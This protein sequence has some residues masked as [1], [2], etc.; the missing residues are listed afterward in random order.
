MNDY[1]VLIAGGG[2]GGGALALALRGSGLRIAVLETRPRETA[3]EDPRP[4][5]L[6]HGSRLILER[7]EL[8]RALDPV[9]PI[10]RI[11]VSQRGGFGRVLLDAAAVGLPALGY[12]VDYAQ[13]AARVTESLQGGW[14]DYLPGTA[15]NRVS[16]DG[17]AAVVELEPARG[18]VITGLLVVADGGMHADGNEAHAVRT[19]DYRQT[20]VTARVTSTVAHA[21]VAYERFTPEGPLALLPAGGDLAL[22][23]STTPERAQRLCAAPDAEFLGELQQAFGN[24]LGRFT[25]VTRRGMFPLALRVA[26][27]TGEPRTV[28][29][30][31]AA[32]TLHPVA[33]QG[34]NLGLRDAWELAAELRRSERERIGAPELLAR[35][36]ARRRLDRG[37]GIWFTHGLARMFSSDL[38]PLRA[39]RGLGLAA[40]AAL[41]PAQEFLVRRMSF[42]AR[43]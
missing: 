21:H 3:A 4:L 26:R 24:R 2:P 30:G 37:G 16:L 11:H 32:Q 29:I 36:A 40:L 5:A 34:L 9:T 35:Y 15:V 14:C 43:G 7:L 42:G 12:V 22:I 20:A 27:D 19:V 28:R 31:N 41:P 6:S 18:R 1:D 39:A 38:A 10:G 13:L 8:W 33:G 25:A 17:D 23:W